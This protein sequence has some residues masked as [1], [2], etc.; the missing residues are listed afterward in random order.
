MDDA[1]KELVAMVLSGRTEAFEPLVAPHRQALLGLAYRLTWNAEDAREVA[2]EALFRAFRYL[3]RYD[4][5]RSFRNWLFR[6]AANEARD[7][8]RK[9]VRERHTIE[10]LAQEPEKHAH[11]EDE[12]DAA[13]VRSGILRCLDVLGQREREVFVLRDLHDLNIKETARALG[14]SSLTVRVSLSRAREK[15]RNA[16]RARMPHLEESR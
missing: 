11:P 3:H 5:E 4:P 16:L 13:E 2:Q 9:K 12:R 7:R 1:E 8:G 10:K 15:V 6:I 14:C